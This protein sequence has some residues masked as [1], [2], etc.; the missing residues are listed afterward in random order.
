VLK[1]ARPEIPMKNVCNYCVLIA[2][3]FLCACAS[4]S[5]GV[6]RAP[7]TEECRVCRYNNDLACVCVKVDTTTPREVYLGRTNYFCSE[8]CRTAFVKRPTKYLPK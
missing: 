7:G 2:L 6:A 1:G 3:C 4:N 8:D 5:R